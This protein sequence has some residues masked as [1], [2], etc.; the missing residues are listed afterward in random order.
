MG[1]HG[2]AIVEISLKEVI[3]DLHKAYADEWLAFY[4]YWYIAQTV[5]GRMYAHIQELMNKL[6][7][8]ELEHAKELAERITKLGDV[9]PAHPAE[10]EKAANFPYVLPPKNT[11]D[12]N[13]IIR[14]VQEAEAGAIDVYSRIA[15]KTLGRDHLTYQLVTH[16]LA[17]EVTH[18][19]IFE[20]LQERS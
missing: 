14:I 2:R 6:A 9:P 4:L 11:S 5:T 17:E 20:N 12:I 1:K 7:A 16:I 3:K 18:E 8:D 10:L 19:D 13:R 15:K